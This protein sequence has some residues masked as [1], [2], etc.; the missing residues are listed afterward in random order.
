MRQAVRLRIEDSIRWLGHRHDIPDLIQAADVFAMPS[1][2]EGLCS[3]L[4]DAMFA[5]LPI[6]STSAG[7]IPELLQRGDGAEPH[8]IMIEPANSGALAG[9]II[10][11]LES[12]RQARSMAKRARDF[13]FEKFTSN[14]MIEGTLAVYRSVTN[15]QLQRAA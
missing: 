9:A 1:L 15:H 7:G 6:V 4:I 11:Q 13:A 3:T 5:G 14:A 12:P 10:E 8:A 2:N